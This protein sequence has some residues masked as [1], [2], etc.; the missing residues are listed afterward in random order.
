MARY[1]IEF[2]LK[3]PLYKET[4]PVVIQSGAV[5]SDTQENKIHIQLKFLNICEK[6]IVLLK[7]KMILMDAI[8]RELG[9]IEKTRQI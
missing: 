9:E 6:A 2:S 7:V 1:K 8:G 4:S 5:V 3:K